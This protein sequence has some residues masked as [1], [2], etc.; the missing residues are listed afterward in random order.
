MTTVAITGSG[1]GIGAGIREHLEAQADKVIGVDLK[2]AEILA[3]L[4]TPEGR[5]QAVG[6][7]N[8]RCEGRLDRLVTCAGV[9]GHVSPKSLVAKV[10][11]FGAVDVFD[12]LLPSLQK[13]Q[14]P[15]AVAIV[16]NSAQIAPI[17]DNPYVLALLEHDEPEACRIIDEMD[18]GPIAYMGSKHALGRAIRRRVRKWGDGRVRLNGVCPGPIRTPLL[19]AGLEDPATRDAIESIDIP[20]GRWGEPSDIAKMVDFL[21]GPNAAW[22][23][24]SMFY[25]DGGNDAEIRPDRY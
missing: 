14:D 19:E 11:Y 22:I 13:G 20:I 16:S 9:G 1:S 6:E 2:N 10:N 17:A 23:H 15:A 21:L 12:A 5:A 24:G 25:V 7:I 3:D 8:E 4:S 18:S